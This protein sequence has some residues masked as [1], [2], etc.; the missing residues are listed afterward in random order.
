MRLGDR[1]WYW[2]W[3]WYQRYNHLVVD[4]FSFTALTRRIDNRYSAA[5][6]DETPEPTPFVPFSNVVEEYQRYQAS[7]T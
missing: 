5:M 1:H 6:R 2:Y 7:P 4:G 3:Y